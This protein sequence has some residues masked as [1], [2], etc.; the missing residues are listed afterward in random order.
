[1]GQHEM[2]GKSDEWY[3]PKYIFDALGCEFNLDVA[4]P[5]NYITHVPAKNILS[6]DSL[7]KEWD[8]FVWCNPPFGGRNGIL[9]WAEKF[10][11]HGNG[12]MLTPDRSSAPWWQYL[13]R[14]SQLIL[15]VAG[16]IKFV[17][18]DGS[19]GNQPANGTTLFSLGG[20][21]LDAL[22]A[23]EKKDLGTLYINNFF[24]P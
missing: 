16:K 2:I 5:E 14:H 13:A 1:M 24:K 4:H 22:I 23:A 17:K 20:K 12:I 15:F 11:Q 8:G 10:I 19:T 7:S 9:P 21:G 3:T 18:P 6:K